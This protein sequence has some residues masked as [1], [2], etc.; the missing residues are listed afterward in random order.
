MAAICQFCGI[1]FLARRPASKFCS[2]SCSVSAQ[3]QKFRDDLPECAN[4]R[5][6]N[7]RRARNGFFCSRSCSDEA[8]RKVCAVDSCENPSESSDLGM[9]GTHKRRFL[10]DLPSSGIRQKRIKGERVLL[11]SGYVRVDNQSEHRLAMARHLGRPLLPTENVHH[12]NGDRGDNR[13]ENLE[14]WS[15]SQPAGQRISDKVAWAI[16][17]L[18]LYAPEALSSQPVQLRAV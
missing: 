15:K 16:D 12:L 3:W 9:C 5:C 11:K 1:H 7:K 4:P 8:R 10:A 6:G 2:R 17:L 14:L 18:A 13:I